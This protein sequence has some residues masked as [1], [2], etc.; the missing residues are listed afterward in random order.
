MHPRFS[1]T[2]H[3]F[4]CISH[5]CEEQVF[6]VVEALLPGVW[7]HFA[8]NFAIVRVWFQ[9][10]CALAEGKGQRG[11]QRRVSWSGPR[12]GIRSLPLTFHYLEPGR[13][14]ITQLQRRA[15]SVLGEQLACLCHTHQDLKVTSQLSVIGV[16]SGH[17]PHLI[18]HRNLITPDPSILSLTKER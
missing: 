11:D 18:L 6:L 9:G 4:E 5:I 17:R 15:L 3:T 14:G 16:F 7:L 10:G 8:H 13:G 1:V 12:S 2:P